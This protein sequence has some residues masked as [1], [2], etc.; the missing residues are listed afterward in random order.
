M[1]KH[2]DKWFQ[3]ANEIEANKPIKDIA[4]EFKVSYQYVTLVGRELKFRK[5]KETKENCSYS[6]R[7]LG[8]NNEKLS[9]A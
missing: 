6:K 5:E 2:C 9:F 8:E 1:T 3:I 7:N 4:K